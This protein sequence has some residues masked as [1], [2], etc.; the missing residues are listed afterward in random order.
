MGMEISLL[1]GAIAELFAQVSNSGVITVAD[2]YG[3][4]AALMEDK[5][6]EEERSCIDRLL[7]AAYRGRLKVVDDLS[8]VT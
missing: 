7:H 3:L 2:R 1:P 8:V 4:M 6:T 5:I